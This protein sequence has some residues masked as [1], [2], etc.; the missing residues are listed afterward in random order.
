MPVWFRR[1]SWK[2]IRSLFLSF[3]PP[4]RGENLIASG[5]GPAPVF[6]SG[7]ALL[8]FPVAVAVIQFIPVLL[9]QFFPLIQNDNRLT[10]LITSLVIGLAIFLLNTEGANKPAGF[11]QWTVAII[12]GLINTGFLMGAAIGLNIPSLVGAASPPPHT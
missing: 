11:R 12:V 2:R 9:H 10:I 3:P 4:P 6:V 7:A 5:Q 1:L 8:S